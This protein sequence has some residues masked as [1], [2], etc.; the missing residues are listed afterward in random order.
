MKRLVRRRRTRGVTLVELLFGIA[1]LLIGAVWLMAAYQ[2]SVH[3]AEVSQQANVALN[4]LRDMME[5]IKTT[6]FTQLTV[7]FPNGTLNGPGGAQAYTNVVGG[8][9]LNTEGITVTHNP[10]TGADPRE[11][12]VTLTWVNRGRTYQRMLSTMRA[13]QAS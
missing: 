7:N 4:D 6:P 10:N 2:W 8:Y 11:L 3:L 12:V 1:A 9:T 5:R 13:S